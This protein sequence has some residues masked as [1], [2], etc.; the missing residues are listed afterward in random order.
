VAFQADEKFRRALAF[1]QAGR[2]AEAERAFK[3][4]LDAQPKHVGALNL[5]GIVMM[6][7]GRFAEAED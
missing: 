1:L 3:Q 6:Q 2:V 4:V 7:L 5:L